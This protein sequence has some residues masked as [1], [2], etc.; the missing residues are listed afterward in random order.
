MVIKKKISLNAADKKLLQEILKKISAGD[1]KSVLKSLKEHPQLLAHLAKEYTGRLTKRDSKDFKANAVMIALENKQFEVAKALLEA[2]AS[3]HFKD[4]AGRTALMIASQRAH[5]PTIKLLLE[6]GAKINA[7][8]IDGLP[9]LIY[10]IG[11][12]SDRKDVLTV[13]KTLL[14]AGADPNLQ[15]ANALAYAN[16]DWENST[17]IDKEKIID[18]LIKHGAQDDEPQDGIDLDD[19]ILEFEPEKD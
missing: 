6:K 8:D 5:N 19:F 11:G 9:P 4:K 13:V 3:V 10:A 2:G 1:E 17:Q 18:V 7:V 15:E 12:E 14:A 16:Y